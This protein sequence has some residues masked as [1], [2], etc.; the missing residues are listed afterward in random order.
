MTP[1]KLAVSNGTYPVPYLV[2]YETGGFFTALYN[3]EKSPIA[4]FNGL[5]ILEAQRLIAQTPLNNTEIAER[6]GFSSVHHFSK[7]FKQK[8]GIAPTEYAKASRI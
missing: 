1:E 2:S 4:Y 8:T 6:L 5:K 3:R 7:A